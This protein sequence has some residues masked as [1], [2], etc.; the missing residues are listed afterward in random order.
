MQADETSPH[1]CYVLYNMENRATYNGYT[2]NFSKRIRQ[3]NCLIKG[4][5]KCTTRQVLQRGV[6]W[7]PLAIVRSSSPAFDHK[8]ALSLEWSIKYPDNK[9]PRSKCFDGWRGRLKGLAMALSNPKFADLAFEVEVYSQDGSD[10]L[11]CCLQELGNMGV[12]IIHHVP[13]PESA[14]CMQT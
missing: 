12:H 10:V 8:R 13:E 3:H 7:L 14:L 9:R 11:Q 1:V 4:G 2:N 6:H 5:A